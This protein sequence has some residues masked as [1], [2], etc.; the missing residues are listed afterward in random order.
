MD[1]DAHRDR[2]TE[3]L[4]QGIA[5]HLLPINEVEI[6]EYT[7]QMLEKFPEMG[8]KKVIIKKPGVHQIAQAMSGRRSP[9]PDDFFLEGT[10]VIDDKKDYDQR[11]DNQGLGFYA[12]AK[13][14]LDTLILTK[15]Y[16]ITPETMTKIEQAMTELDKEKPSMD[17]LENIPLLYEGVPINLTFKPKSEYDLETTPL[18]Y[19]EA[20]ALTPHDIKTQE[21][22][23]EQR[24]ALAQM[25]RQKIAE[26]FRTLIE[27]PNLT[28]EEKIRSVL[29]TL[30]DSIIVTGIKTGKDGKEERTRSPI[31]KK[32]TIL[33]YAL[34]RTPENWHRLKSILV[35]GE[36][37]TNLGRVLQEGDQIYLKFGRR[38]E[39]NIQTDWLDKVNI[40]PEN[41]R[42]LIDESIEKKGSCSRL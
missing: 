32:A 11:F 28:K 4:R 35:N 13:S 16:Q 22:T 42:I 41:A 21:F 3:K 25:R 39:N 34:L 33:D 36:V 23:L 8:F 31:P 26:Q 24:R 12:R 9:K 14:I 10:V 27:D 17:L 5:D 20:V 18:T 6:I 1:E 38:Y 7:E 2:F 29:I 19:L 15:G 30:P 37:E 40:D